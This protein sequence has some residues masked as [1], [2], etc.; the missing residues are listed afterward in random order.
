MADRV[1]LI[2]FISSLEGSRTAVEIFIAALTLWWHPS[3]INMSD[4]LLAN[5]LILDQ[6]IIAWCL[7]DDSSFIYN[8]NVNPCTIV[9]LL[10][11]YSF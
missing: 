11:P 5:N 3:C 4:M 1:M 10:V 2:L 6:D 8:V 9:E 7:G